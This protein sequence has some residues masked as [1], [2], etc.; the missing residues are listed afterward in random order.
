M[1][2]FGELWNWRVCMEGECSFGCKGVTDRPG[3]RRGR[4][5]GAEAGLGLVGS[6]VFIDMYINICLVVCRCA[7]LWATL[8]M[9]GG[10]QGGEKPRI[11]RMC[12]DGRGED[13]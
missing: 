12:A 13:V 7:R 10:D 5:Y 2:K 3:A 11:S 9:G 6:F 1:P 4:E 8:R